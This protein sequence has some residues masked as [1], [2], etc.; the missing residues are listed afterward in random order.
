[1]TE[2]DTLSKGNLQKVAADKLL[3]FIAVCPHVLKLE[4]EAEQFVEDLNNAAKNFNECT[5]RIQET[6]SE[7][8]PFIAVYPKF[9]KPGIGLKK[10]VEELGKA[11]SKFD[12][13]FHKHEPIK[14]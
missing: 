11:A 10:F 12:L 8:L 14:I 6:I 13:Y 1:M 3:P 2:Q 7:L 5:T 9:F 4:I